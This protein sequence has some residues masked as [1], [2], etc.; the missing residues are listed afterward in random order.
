MNN[1][2]VLPLMARARA[3]EG[4]VHGRPYSSIFSDLNSSDVSVMTMPR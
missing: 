2:L 3:A 1:V 4:M